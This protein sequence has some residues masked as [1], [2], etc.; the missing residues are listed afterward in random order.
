[1][2]AMITLRPRSTIHHTDGGWFSAYWHLSFDD[3]DDPRTP[4]SGTCASSTTTR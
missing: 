2:S 1:M 4:G 3:Y